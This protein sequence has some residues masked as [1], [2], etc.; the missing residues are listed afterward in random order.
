MGFATVTG[1]A[2]AGSVTGE[3][4][5]DAINARL[6]R[7]QWEDWEN[8][9]KPYQDDSFNTVLDPEERARLDAEALA[10]SQTAVDTAFDRTENRIQTL[11]SRLPQANADPQMTE[12]RDRQLELA[13]RGSKVDAYNTTQQALEDREMQRISG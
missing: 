1:G 3:E 5:P 2:F 10:N 7:S 11:A 8:R 12:A 9:F 4:E 6:L 13:R